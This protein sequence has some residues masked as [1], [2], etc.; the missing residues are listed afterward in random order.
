MSYHR[1]IYETAGDRSAQE[2]VAQALRAALQCDLDP[3]P[4][5]SPVDYIARRSGALC[6]LVEVKVRRTPMR[7]YPTYMIALSKLAAMQ[8]LA[9]VAGVPAIL[10]VGWSDAIG[11]VKPEG[12]TDVTGGGRQDRGDRRDQEL[13]AHIPIEKFRVIA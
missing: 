2:R 9:M 13:V 12:I 10:A 7:A 4:P 6:G 5:L 8:S 11:W 3:T 1:P